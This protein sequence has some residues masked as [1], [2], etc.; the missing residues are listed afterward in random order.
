[1]NLLA[2]SGGKKDSDVALCLSD[3]MQ[4]PVVQNH[5][6]NKKCEARYVSVGC[7]LLIYIVDTVS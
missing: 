6:R 4:T 1:M 5:P 2:A 7:T 3:K